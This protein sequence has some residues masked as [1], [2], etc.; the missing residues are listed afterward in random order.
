MPS[1]P[2][3]QPDPR[4]LMPQRYYGTAVG[5]ARQAAKNEI[6]KLKLSEMT[7]KQ[8]VMEAARILHKVRGEGWGWGSIA[9][10][11]CALKM[12]WVV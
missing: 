6:E 10:G 9:A 5:K 4:P 12:C 11:A 2:R 7:C 1:L 3:S 8:A